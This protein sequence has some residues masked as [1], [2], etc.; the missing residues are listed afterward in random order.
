MNEK[1][2]T[3]IHDDGGGIQER[4]NASVATSLAHSES[5]KDVVMLYLFLAAATEFL[6]ILAVPC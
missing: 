6:Y 1:E 4:G 5:N 3:I 2:N